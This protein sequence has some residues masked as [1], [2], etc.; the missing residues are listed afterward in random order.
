MLGETQ[1][2]LVLLLSNQLSIFFAV[3]RMA[4]HACLSYFLSLFVAF[5]C[6]MLIDFCCPVLLDLLIVACF[7]LLLMVLLLRATYLYCCFDL[8]GVA[9]SYYMP[10]VA[11]CGWL[12]LA[13]CMVTCMYAIMNLPYIQ[14]IHSKTVLVLKEIVECSP[15]SHT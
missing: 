2:T 13:V 12:L 3:V 5:C 8:F 6:Q 9:C 7:Y 1:I 4:L 15:P 14:C 11:Y 10:G